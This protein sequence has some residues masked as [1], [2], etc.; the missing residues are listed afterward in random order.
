MCIVLVEK[1]RDLSSFFL[2]L[3]V[4]FF[5]RKKVVD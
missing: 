4:C 3:V 5:G 1:G 2:L